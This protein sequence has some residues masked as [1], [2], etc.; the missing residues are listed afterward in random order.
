MLA[1]AVYNSVM[2]MHAAPRIVRL[3]RGDDKVP[4]NVV[5]GIHYG[6]WALSS[7]V[8][9]VLALVWLNYGSIK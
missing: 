2:A 4:D 5:V 9:I 3:Y 8:V 7:L 6:M 1:F